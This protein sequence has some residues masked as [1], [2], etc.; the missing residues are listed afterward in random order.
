MGD[1]DKNRERS[2]V[3]PGRFP[4][5]PWL[6]FR[7]RVP[8]TKMRRCP[9][10]TTAPASVQLVNFEDHECNELDVSDNAVDALQFLKLFQSSIS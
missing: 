5:N 7:V 3:W 9:L 2:K 6:R 4:H 8:A 1:G 10:L